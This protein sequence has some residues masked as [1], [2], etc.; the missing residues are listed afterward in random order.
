MASSR[1]TEPWSELFGPNITIPRVTENILDYLM[2]PTVLPG[3]LYDLMPLR[4]V[5]KSLRDIVDNYEPVWH[6]FD[7]EQPLLMP[8]LLGHVH[9]IERLR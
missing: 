8:T 1:T 7:Y 9:N 3:E 5:N 4:L 2:D 6:C